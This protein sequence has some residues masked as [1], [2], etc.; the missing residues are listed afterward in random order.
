MCRLFARVV[1]RCRYF[2]YN[3]DERANASS[4]MIYGSATII[5]VVV[6]V[7]YV[8]VCFVKISR[9]VLCAVLCTRVNALKVVVCSIYFGAIA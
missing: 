5:V 1:A 2:I 9:Y 4:D 8:L 7:A 3:T 6:I